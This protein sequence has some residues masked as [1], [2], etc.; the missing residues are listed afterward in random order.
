M[1][2]IIELVKPYFERQAVRLLFYIILCLGS[3]ALSFA[4]PYITG[5]FIDELI[6]SENGSF[7]YKYC[8]LYFALFI[9][10]SVINYISGISYVRLQMGAGYNFNADVVSHIHRI[11]PILLEKMDTSYLS[12]QINNDTNELVIFVLTF[13]QNIIANICTFIIPAYLL[14]KISIKLTMLIL[15]STVVYGIVYF[16]FKDKVSAFNREFK[17]AQARYFSRLHEQLRYSDFIRRHAISDWFLKRLKLAFKELMAAAIKSRKLGI[18]ISLSNGLIL[19]MLQIALFFIGGMAIVNGELMVGQF[20]IFSAYFSMMTTSITYFA[21]IG[22]TIQESLVSYGRIKRILDIPECMS[23]NIKLETIDHISIKGLSFSYG[24]DNVLNEIDCEFEK[25]KIYI[26]RGD[27]GSGKTTFINLLAGMYSGTY[28]Q[29]I[30]IDGVRMDHVD[31]DYYR[32]HLVAFA[33]QNTPLIAGTLADN[34]ALDRKYDFADVRIH[35][36]ERMFSLDNIS[37]HTPDVYKV[38]INDKNSN[39]SGGEKQ[40]IALIRAFMKDAPM[41]IFDEPTSALDAGSRKEFCEY[42]QKVK[43]DKIII[44]VTH[45]EYLMACGDVILSLS[46]SIIV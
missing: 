13:A 45:D 27:N 31:L 26:I 8:I 29:S 35:K 37:N 36:L 15:G 38:N 9:I 25:G 16:L 17:E 20:T 1:K 24:K 40:K 41:M 33:E 12:Q 46:D 6:V 7:L 28:E 5:N 14:S 30:A 39:I 22:K 19:V 2:K 21:T 11:D 44:I 23:G 3:S 32:N 10:S 4:S 42:I 43:K 34:I 18:Y